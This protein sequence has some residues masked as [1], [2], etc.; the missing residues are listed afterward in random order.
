MLNNIFTFLLNR[1]GCVFFHS[2]LPVQFPCLKESYVHCDIW[3]HEWF[4]SPRSLSA[5]NKSMD[6]TETSCLWEYYKLHLHDILELFLYFQESIRT[7]VTK[8]M[9][10]SACLEFGPSYT[11]AVDKNLLSWREVCIHKMA[12]TA[13]MT[14][15]RLSCLSCPLSAVFEL[16]LDEAMP[17][18]IG[19]IHVSTCD[20]Q[21]LGSC[22]RRN[23]G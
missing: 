12:P 21:K 11:S 2:N 16:F 18:W 1:F 8:S 13:P 23:L 10:V 5:D 22:K 15:V 3:P 7:C 19:S 9:T 6:T 20:W 4:S 17:T 14:T